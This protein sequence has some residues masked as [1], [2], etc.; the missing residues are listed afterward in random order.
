MQLSQIEQSIKETIK[1]YDVIEDIA[2]YIKN[3]NEDFEFSL[4]DIELKYCIGSITKVF[5]AFGVMMLRED[6]K[7][8]LDDLIETHIP[9]LKAIKYAN[10]NCPRISIRDLITHHSGVIRD[11]PEQ[12]EESYE[13]VFDYLTKEAA[14]VTP[15]IA[16]SYSNVGYS[17]LGMLIE[18][19]SGLTYEDFI[20]NNLLSVLG[21]KESF[22]KLD[23]VNFGIGNASGALFSTLKDMKKFCEYCSSPNCLKSINPYI[24]FEMQKLS[25]QGRMIEGGLGWHIDRGVIGH[26]GCYFPYQSHFWFDPVKNFSV[27]ILLKVKNESELALSFD[28]LER[29]YEQLGLSFNSYLANFVNDLSM[30]FN[31]GKNLIFKDI[32]SDDFFKEF[33]VE[34]L[35]TI[36]SDL[37]EKLGFVK[38]TK[39]HELTSFKEANIEFVGERNRLLFNLVKGTDDRISSL[40]VKSLP[41]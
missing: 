18:R 24:Q 1:K 38:S 10:D 11:I 29:V 26:D 31:E 22:F 32:I 13:L 20:S 28:I 35:Q 8:N 6:G 4:N 34:Q 23:E 9:E 2:I 30:Y 36:F 12:I 15:R 17:L 14:P 33:G 19:L 25:F 41:K 16:Y 7:L 37:K 5:T 3:G 27:I 40:L 39:V 21:L